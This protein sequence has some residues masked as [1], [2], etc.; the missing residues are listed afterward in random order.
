MG[1]EL[2]D[3][4]QVRAH[5]YTRCRWHAWQHASASWAIACLNSLQVACWFREWGCECTGSSEQSLRIQICEWLA[6]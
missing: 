3:C 6:C 5:M 2:G 1:V 4:I